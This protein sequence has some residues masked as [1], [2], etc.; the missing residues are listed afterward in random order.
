MNYY[1]Y[2]IRYSF[3]IFT[4]VELDVHSHLILFHSFSSRLHETQLVSSCKNISG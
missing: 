1:H 4:V 3:P 2:T